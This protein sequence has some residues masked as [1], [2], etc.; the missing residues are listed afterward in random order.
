MSTVFMFGFCFPNCALNGLPKA[1]DLGR[2]PA[3]A[4]ITA[5]AEAVPYQRADVRFNGA[6]VDTPFFNRNALG[7][8]TCFSGPAIIEEPTATTV[9]PPDASVHVDQSGSLLIT[10]GGLG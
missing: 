10:L 6:V 7:V 8:D 2:A 9:V 4:E 5:P 3:R 1:A